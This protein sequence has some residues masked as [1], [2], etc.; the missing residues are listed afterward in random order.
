[1][2]LNL[3]SKL[4]Y[5]EKNAGWELTIKQEQNEMPLCPSLLTPERKVGTRIYFA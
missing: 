2:S 3:T 1:M 5:G 4:M